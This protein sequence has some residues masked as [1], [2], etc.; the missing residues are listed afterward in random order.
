MI[1]S[2]NGCAVGPVDRR[3]LD[4]ARASM[5]PIVLGIASHAL[6]APASA[7]ADSTDWAAFASGDRVE[8]DAACTG[9]WRRAAIGS[10]GTDP[11]NAKARRFT[12]K[13]EHGSD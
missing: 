10:I 1:S 6:C 4:A 3:V 9:N 5:M 11:Y 2:G 12:V 7:A 13:R 8:V